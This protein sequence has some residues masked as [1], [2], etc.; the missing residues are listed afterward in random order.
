M[1]TLAAETLNRIRSLE[2]RARQTIEGFITGG[3]RTKHHGFSVEFLQHREN[4]PGDDIRHI[5]W[6][7][8][9]RK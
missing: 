7:V 6:K 3:H 9:G 4:V 8:Y 1:Q 5:D 2:L